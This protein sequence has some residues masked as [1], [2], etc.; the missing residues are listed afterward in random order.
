MST[1]GNDALLKLSL[2]NRLQQ[3]LETALAKLFLETVKPKRA[4]NCLLARNKIK[5]SE[6]YTRLAFLKT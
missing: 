4:F 6:Q 1:L 3:F 5:N 2:T